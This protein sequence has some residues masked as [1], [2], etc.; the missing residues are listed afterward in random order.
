MQ[1]PGGLLAVP[2][3]QRYGRLP[4][5]FWSQFLTAIMVIGVALSPDYAC[6]TAFRTL[7]GFFNTAPQIV[8]L[9]IVHDMFFF[10]E[11]TRRVNVWIFCL[12]GGPFIGPFLAAWF[13]Q[14]VSWRADYGI[15]AGF[16]G[17]TTVLIVLFG[18]ETLYQRDSAEP[19]I[20]KERGILGRIK[21]L[22]GI[23]GGKMTGR[24][25]ILI[26]LKD[27]VK[28][29]LKPQILFISKAAPSSVQRSVLTPNS[30]DLCHGA[31][32][33]DNRH[34]PDA[35]TIHRSTPIHI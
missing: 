15:L 19:A 30:R 1:G 5:L 22:V 24:P 10:H 32:R 8:G 3:V 17:L 34:Q 13:L 11:R 33:L 14:G 27:I 25:K 35:P 29:Q 12:L 21:L 4:V 18:D 7:Q 20:K 9:S 16:H 26:I 23:T 31:S 6:L 2:L 28:I